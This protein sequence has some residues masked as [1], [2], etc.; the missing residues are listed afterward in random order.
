MKGRL[1]FDELGALPAPD[2]LARA[3]GERVLAAIRDVMQREGGAIPFAR[4][5]DLAL[6]AP[7][8]GYYSA[9]SAKLGA[10]GDFVTAPEISPLFGRCLAHQAAQVLDA[11]GGG[12]I[13]EIGA[14]SGVL[15]CDVLAELER[16]GTLPERYA[17]LEISAD[18][19]ARQEALIATR[20]PHLAGRVSWL[21]RLPSAG[22]RGLML[23]NELLDAMPVHLLLQSAGD[24]LEAY[25]RWDQDHFAW[26]AGPPADARLVAR[27][28]AIFEECGRDVFIDGYRFEI[29][30]AMESWLASAGAALDAGLLLLIDYGYSRRQYYHPQRVSGTLMCHYRHRA[31]DDPLIL[32]G[33]QDITAHVDFTALAEAAVAREL[34]L[35]GYNGQAWFLFGC[36]LQELV[37][38]EMASASDLIRARISQQIQRL[39]LP[40]EMGEKIKIMALS[41]RLDIPLCG[42]SLR[43]ERGSL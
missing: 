14:G 2:A 15:A 34:R 40:G 29:N 3:H 42:F 27:L 16:L 7:G 20:I 35:A 26:A 13:L 25:V 41:R 9:G 38:D 17:I 43:D 5:M 19:R 4:Y 39:T 32:A 37:A 30:L 10:E 1:P 12:E 28:D 22:F 24:P 18:L 23:A 33:L 8:L 21:D 11:L 31:H 36:G 6:H